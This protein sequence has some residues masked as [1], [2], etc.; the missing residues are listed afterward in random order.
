MQHN[1]IYLQRNLV[2]RPIHFLLACSLLFL[3]SGTSD[4]YAS[5]SHTSDI[6]SSYDEYVKNNRRHYAHNCCFLFAGSLSENSD[7]LAP[8]KPEDNLRVMRKTP[9]TFRSILPIVSFSNC[10]FPFQIF[11]YQIVIPDFC[12]SVFPLRI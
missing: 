7:F 5:Y 6:Y 10:S 4:S 12:L 1:S 8:A 9:F 3:F 11:K 2:M